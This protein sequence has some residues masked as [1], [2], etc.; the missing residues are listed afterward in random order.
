MIFYSY[1]KLPEGSEDVVRIYPV[2]NGGSFSER[3]GYSYSPYIPHIFPIQGGTKELWIEFPN[4]LIG[5]SC[6]YVFFHPHFSERTVSG[7]C[8]HAWVGHM[9][10]CPNYCIC[11]CSSFPVSVDVSWIHGAFGPFFWQMTIRTQALTVT[12]GDWTLTNDE[13]K[14]KK[15]RFDKWGLKQ[16]YIR[17]VFVLTFVFL[18]IV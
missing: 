10:T 12:L 15:Q 8:H 17:K 2:V 4:H 6:F 14:K 3:L 18:A 5:I 11:V 16:E 1:V 13:T 9:T 7:P